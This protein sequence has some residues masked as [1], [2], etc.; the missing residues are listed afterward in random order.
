M[1]SCETF[2]SPCLLPF[3]GQCEGGAC[4]FKRDQRNNQIPKSIRPYEED[5]ITDG[6]YHCAWSRSPGGWLGQ[7]T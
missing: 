1:L 5:P 2:S 7:V 3:G 6:D 4:S